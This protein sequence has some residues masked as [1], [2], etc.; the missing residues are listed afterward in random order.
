MIYYLEHKYI[1]KIGISSFVIGEF[2]KKIYRIGYIFSITSMSFNYYLCMDFLCNLRQ[3]F[4][5]NEWELPTSS[6]CFRPFLCHY[7]VLAFV[8]FA[9]TKTQWGWSK[10]RKCLALYLG[11]KIRWKNFQSIWKETI[12]LQSEIKKKLDAIFLPFFKRSV[13]L[14]L[15][16]ISK[17]LELDEYGLRYCIR[18]LK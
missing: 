10:P 17:R 5:T 18:N 16:L 4:S 12:V 14:V 7:H 11:Q 15:L 13:N 2:K 8:S 6:M 9:I 1:N 3:I